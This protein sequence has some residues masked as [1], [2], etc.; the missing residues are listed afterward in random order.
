MERIC[1]CCKEKM[2]NDFNVKASASYVV[3]AKKDYKS[4]AL[5][6]AICP[7][8]GYTMMYTDNYKDLK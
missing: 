2:I 7:T 4:I 5:K 6:A 3:Q 8:C 1:I